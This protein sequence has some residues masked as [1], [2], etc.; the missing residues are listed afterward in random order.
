[1]STQVVFPDI[2]HAVCAPLFF[3]APPFMGGLQHRVILTIVRSPVTRVTDEHVLYALTAGT[4]RARRSA[5]SLPI[6]LRT[7]FQ[8]EP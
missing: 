1:M 4:V 5:A 3:L 8:E 7:A 2:V 6:A